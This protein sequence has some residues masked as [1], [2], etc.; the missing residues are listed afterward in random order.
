MRLLI[1]SDSHDRWDNLSKA[2][3]IGNERG[4]DVLLHA[5]DFISPPGIETL[6]EFRGDVHIVWGN[7]DGEKVGMERGIAVHSH[8]T[9]H[10]DVMDAVIGT[11]RIYMNHYPGIAELAVLS[12]KYDLVVYG[13]THDYREERSLHGTLL[14]NPGEIQ[15]YRTGVPTCAILDTKT[16]CVEKIILSTDTHHTRTMESTN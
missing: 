8:I 11:L 13:H 4:C 5:G 14:I 7:C 3:T 6:A 1:L 2:I 12:Q 15:G 9:H 16:G 10:G